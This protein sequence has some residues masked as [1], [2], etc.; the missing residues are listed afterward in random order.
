MKQDSN[1]RQLTQERLDAS[2]IG[3]AYVKVTGNQLIT[4]CITHG[5]LHYETI[6]LTSLE[7]FG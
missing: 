4:S 5:Q 6:L 3:V 2:P 1:L 7:L